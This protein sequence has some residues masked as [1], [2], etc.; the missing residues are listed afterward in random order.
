[1]TE[2]KGQEWAVRR[3]RSFRVKFFL[4]AAGSVLLALVLSGLFA[5]RNFNRLGH[6]ASAKI[7]EGLTDASREYLSNYIRT[8]AE[9]ARLILD[10]AFAEVQVLADVMQS[11]QDHPKDA[12]TLGAALAKTDAF[13]GPLVPLAR[14][15]EFLWAQNQKPA[16]SV[17]S[18]WKPMLEGDGTVKPEVLETVQDT[19]VLDLLL[20]KLNGYD[21]C[22]ALMRDNLTR[23]IPI[24]IISTLD[25]PDSMAKAKL[26]GARNFMKKPYQLDDLLREINRL[27]PQG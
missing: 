24:L 7:Q 1:M 11:L 17:V 20:P 23:H 6:D 22:N 13:G 18:I 14:S 25:N 21:V 5:V 27:L 26:C 3:S 9:R 12:R 15:N 16:P 2:I 10:Q 8:I 19:A 4:V